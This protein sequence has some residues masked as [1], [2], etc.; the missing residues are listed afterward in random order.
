MTNL[1]QFIAQELSIT[2]DQVKNALELFSEGATTPFIARYRKERTGTL[3]ETQLRDILD[4]HTYLTELQD[5]KKAI[6]KAIEEQVKLT[7]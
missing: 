3:N 5:R 2:P 1:E 4:R 7:P 6:L